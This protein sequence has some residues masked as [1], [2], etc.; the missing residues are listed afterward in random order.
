M[1]HSKI[2]EYFLVMSDDQQKQFY[3]KI[4]SYVLKKYIEDIFQI[5][6]IDDD[7]AIDKLDKFIKFSIG[8][9]GKEE[10]EKDKY[11]YQYQYQY[12]EPLHHVPYFALVRLRFYL[13]LKRNKKDIWGALV[14]WLS[15]CT[16]ISN[17]TNTFFKQYHLDREKEVFKILNVQ[18]IENELK[19]K[20]H[21][22]PLGYVQKVED[23]QMVLSYLGKKWF[24]SR[25]NF[26]ISIRLIRKLNHKNLKTK[27]TSF[28][29]HIT[30]FNLFAF[31][32]SLLSIIIFTILIFSFIRIDSD[33][34]RVLPWFWA[35]FDWRSHTLARGVILYFVYPIAILAILL[36]FIRAILLPRLIGGIMVGYLFLISS[37]RM[38]AFA[39]QTTPYDVTLISGLSIVLSFF[40]LRFE[41][42]RRIGSDHQDLWQR[43]L[44]VFSL[45]FIESTVLGLSTLEL[46]SN[47]F[48]KFLA[49]QIPDYLC[50]IAKFI[51]PLGG[52][53]YPKVIILYI[54]LALLVGIII[55]LFWEEKP[56]SQL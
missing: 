40:F 35:E 10:E 1:S 24:P 46:F 36:P 2:L 43:T 19:F 3:E 30:C 56:I 4:E 29:K 17:E 37:D 34:Q 28:F 13:K 7:E 15:V 16:T 6:G 21:K 47:I 23:R 53:L 49:E 32:T 25:Y 51:G 31:L 14:E 27:I 12:R 5:D 18:A 42:Q 11:Q 45:G 38:V 41:V 54:P 22:F 50:K 52:T 20:E 39:L 26:G 44:S 33:I 9:K 48:Q 8:K 55:Q